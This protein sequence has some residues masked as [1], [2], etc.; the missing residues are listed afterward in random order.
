MFIKKINLEN[1]RNYEKQ[2]IELCKDIN[3]I[4]GN[5]AQGKTNILESIFLCSMGK[6]F[7][8]KKDK[9][10][11]KFE[12]DK[13]TVEVE[14][15]KCDRDGKIRVEL[16]S[17]KTFFSNGV[18]QNK[19]SD[20]IGK[21]NTVIFTPDTIDIIKEDPETRRKF[22]NM[23]IS[24]LRPKYIHLMNTYKNALEQRNNY[25][26]QIKLENKPEIMLDIW[27]EQLSDL[28][29]KIFEYR[30]LYMKKFSDKINVIHN[31][32]TNSGKLTEKIT[33]KYYSDGNSRDEFLSKMKSLHGLDIKRGYTS[34]RNT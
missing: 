7:R 15:Q 28:S 24:S 21:V 10:L 4:Y 2:E 33:I 22:L 11:I 25:L 14:Y 20:I 18:K 19:V 17:K 8:A 3:I 16:D 1:F 32:L 9:E 23:L 31:K 29:S 34:S 6:S 5:N 26:K 30:S 12:N 27:D 13:S